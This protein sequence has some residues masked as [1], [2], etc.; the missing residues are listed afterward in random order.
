MAVTV[1]QAEGV[2]ASYPAAPDGLS[3]AAAALDPEMVWQRIESYIAHRYS[4]RDIEWIVEG[5]GEW[6]P[7]L[8]PA[9]IS[10]VE[11]WCER[12]H[13]WETITPDASPLGG[14]WLSA[15]GPFRFTATV[16]GGDVPASV[17]TAWSRLAEYMAAKPGTPGATSEST[18]AGSVETSKSRDANWMA[19]AMQNSGAAD[20]LRTYRKV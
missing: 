6:H 9:T 3:T 1:R 10:K 13:E 19:Q 4:E 11:V 2:P 15:T 7:P 5:P 12:A 18:R 16:G 8:S 14:Y 20:L 17:D